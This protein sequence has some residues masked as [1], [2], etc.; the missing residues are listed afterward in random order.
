MFIGL[1]LVP[2]LLFSP[3][4]RPPPSFAFSATAVD[5]PLVGRLLRSGVLEP[6]ASLGELSAAAS[7]LSAWRRALV[8][9]R[10]PDFG[11]IDSD[12]P[13]PP[14]PLLGHLTRT[15]SDLGLPRMTAR[16]PSLV[17]AA[18]TA[19]L[20]AAVSFDQAEGKLL[21]E[22][23][24]LETDARAGADQYF[25]S[26]PTL[27]EEDQE[28]AEDVP[29]AL[30]EDDLARQIDDLAR[31]LAEALGAEWSAPLAGV[32]AIEALGGAAGADAGA[33]TAAPGQQFSLSDGLWKHAGWKTIEVRATEEAPLIAHDCGMGCGSTS[34]PIAAVNP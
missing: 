26:A 13:W 27:C 30:T 28:A 29:A 34:G 14:E 11:G 20:G 6:T 3:A 24:E 5:D 19:V 21:A 7:G 12:A 18:L 2:S 31:E 8:S 9:G 22:E 10:C 16:H 1:A 32:R 17:A 33:L 15:M 4:A 23:P 25:G